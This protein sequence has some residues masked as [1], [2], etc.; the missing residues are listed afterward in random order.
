[1]SGDPGTPDQTPTEPIKPASCVWRIQSL[2][3]RIGPF[4]GISDVIGDM[5]T[6]HGWQR[7]GTPTF[8]SF[9]LPRGHQGCRHSGFAESDWS[10]RSTVLIL[11]DILHLLEG[12]LD[13][14]RNH[15]SDEIR[16]V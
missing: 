7:P 9:P 8:L 16:P 13:R 15:I 11:L 1:M 3:I 6:T 10:Y 2:G 12:Y 14:P 5:G 4:G